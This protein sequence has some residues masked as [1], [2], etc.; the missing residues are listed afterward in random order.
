MTRIAQMLAACGGTAAKF[1]A[2]EVYNEGWMLRLVLDWF[3]RAGLH[4]H[5][6]AFSRNSRWFSEAQL[7]SAF[8]PRSRPDPLAEGWTHADGII[9]QFTVRPGARAEPIFEAE[10]SQF[11]VTEAKL[12]SPLSSGVTNASDYDQAARNVACMAFAMSESAC[13][14]ERLL[15]FGFYVIAPEIQV[16][17]GIFEDFLRKRSIRAKVLSRVEAYRSQRGSHGELR[18]WFESWFEPTLERV[19]IE[20][21][22]WESLVSFVAV[23]DS[24]M[25]EKLADFYSRCL[26]F[27]RPQTKGRT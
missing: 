14:I 1:P 2:T 19:S 3:S 26:D 27:N 21:L 22:C 23:A 24:S 17:S 13:S 10:A 5:P 8:L 16:N 6:L 20:A 18:R 15:S 9:G 25:G 11:V 4:D 12:F 7:P